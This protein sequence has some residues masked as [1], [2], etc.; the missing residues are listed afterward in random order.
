MP[1]LFNDPF[2]VEYDIHTITLD[3]VDRYFVDVLAVDEGWYLRNCKVA[4]WADDLQNSEDFEQEFP[5]YFVYDMSEVYFVV[6]SIQEL[7]A[8]VDQEGQ[9]GDWTLIEIHTR[10]S[11]SPTEEHLVNYQF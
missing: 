8:L 7:E 9:F 3:G 10:R 11:S 2:L 1:E 4:I 6:S 5:E